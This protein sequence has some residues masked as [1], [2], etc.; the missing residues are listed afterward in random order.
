MCEAHSW[1]LEFWPLL[2][3]PLKYL[4]NYKTQVETVMTYFNCLLIILLDILYIYIYMCVCVCVETNYLWSTIE[5][6]WT[7]PM[8]Q[9]P[10][11][12]TEMTL[13]EEMKVIYDSPKIF[14]RWKV[15]SE[16]FV[17]G[18]LKPFC[19]PEYYFKVPSWRGVGHWIRDV[20]G[21]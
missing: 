12:I 11:V 21:R 9:W 4:L 18:G 13:K 19:H 5:V 16:T 1:R 14:P 2:P 17:W 10:K 7:G 20:G 8:A 3:T 15:T 6:V